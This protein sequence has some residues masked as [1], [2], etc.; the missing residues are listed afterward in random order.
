MQLC[1]DALRTRRATTSQ[2]II[3]A[4]MIAKVEDQPQGMEKEAQLLR[5]LAQVPGISAAWVGGPTPSG[6]NVTVSSPE[7]FTFTLHWSDDRCSET[8]ASL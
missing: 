2:R 1:T 4:S 6:N 3:T 7:I 5:E 8:R